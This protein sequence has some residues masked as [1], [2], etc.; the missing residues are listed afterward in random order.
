VREVSADRPVEEMNGVHTS[1]L[2]ACVLDLPPLAVTV[3]DLED[4]A[5]CE[6]DPIRVPGVRSICT[7]SM[8]CAVPACEDQAPTWIERLG[9]EV[10]GVRPV[11]LRTTGLDIFVI[12]RVFAVFIHDQHAEAKS[13][14][15]VTSGMSTSGCARRF[16]SSAFRPQSPRIA[17]TSFRISSRVWFLQ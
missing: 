16:S 5:L 11:V 4:L 1:N 14:G 6:A 2:T 3:H 8:P 10:H 13:A 7:P 17:A 9:L 12:L 15:R